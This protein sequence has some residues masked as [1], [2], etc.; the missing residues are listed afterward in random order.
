MLSYTWTPRKTLIT[1]GSTVT[2]YNLEKR[3]VVPPQP[4][5]ISGKNVTIY[6]EK[7]GRYF[8][9]I[10]S[11][12]VSTT[13]YVD[14]NDP[15]NDGGGPIP[16]TSLPERLSEASL[17]ATYV[18]QSNGTLGAELVTNGDF[19]ADLT[20]W[21]GANWAWV[22]GAAK[23]TAGSTAAL[24]QAATAPTVG[25]TYAVT[26]TVSGLTAGDV[27]AYLG[28]TF[29]ATATNGTTTGYVT[30]TST[31]P[32]QF[33]PASNFDGSVDSVSVKVL[34]SSPVRVDSHTTFTKPIKLHTGIEIPTGLPIRIGKDALKANTKG[35][36]NTPSSNIAIGYQ[37]GMNTTEGHVTAVGYRAAEATSGTGVVTA[38]GKWA[39]MST[40]TGHS[41][42]FGNAAGLLATTGNIDVFGDEAASKVTTGTGIA[43]FGYYALNGLVTGTATAFGH[44]AGMNCGSAADFT[45]VGWQAGLAATGTGMVAVGKLA[46]AA[47]TTGR[48]TAIGQEALASNTI[49]HST[50]VGYR[51]G[52]YSTG[53]VTLIGYQAG[54]A[55]T[56]GR[57]TALGNS[58]ALDFTTGNGVFVGHQTGYGLTPANA[59][60]T[61]AQAVLIGDYANRSVPSAT[62]LENYVGV[63]YAALV[64]AS[65][66]TAIGY[67]A[68]ANHSQSVALGASSTTTAANQL[69]IGDRDIESTRTAGGVVLKSP[70]GTR[71]KITVA[72]GGTIAVAAA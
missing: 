72:N 49:Q 6:V 22:A 61:D 10:Q 55:A 60:K 52:L 39:G 56:T 34:T 2:I 40:T 7:E 13:H 64:G 16:E 35:T 58:A 47:T 68:A 18:G 43:A 65:N 1:E 12:T 54:L 17:N 53:S 70:D 24:L 62:Y 63:G 50:A 28:G 3:L 29:I 42:L 36:Y 8:V 9:K 37:A 67:M 57:V 66:A 20:G 59:P 48:A 14:V 46:G 69:M 38:F 23:H 21:T 31:D 41:T 11:Q 32:I 4:P 71:Y 26:F 44:K 25:T 51:A 19:A 15:A 45:A 33:V 30:A 5:V 27:S